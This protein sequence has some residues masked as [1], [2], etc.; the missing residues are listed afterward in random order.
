MLKKRE[1]QTGQ[2]ILLAEFLNRLGPALN[3]SGLEQLLNIPF[4]SIRDWRNGR[5]ALAQKH[6]DTL[7]AWAKTIEYKKEPEHEQ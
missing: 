4:R 3:V 2:E 6:I 7:E 1:F 5:Q